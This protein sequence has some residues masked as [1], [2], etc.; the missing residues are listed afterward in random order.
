MSNPLG[1][2]GPP[3]PYVSEPADPRMITDNMSDAGSS[4]SSG[5][6]S[7]V[8]SR[9]TGSI[10]T[11]PSA[12]PRGSI[13]SRHTRAS[14]YS[15]A[16]TNYEEVPHALSL[17]EWNCGGRNVYLTGSWDNYNEKIPM[18]SI[19]PGNFRCTVKVPQERLEFKFI[20]DGVEKFNPDYPTMYTETGERVNVKH[21]DPDGKKNKTGA[22]RKIVSK[23]SGLD[24]YSPFHMAETLSMIVFRV[25]YVLTIP[26]AIYYFYWLAV[27]TERGGGNRKDAPVSWIVFMIAEMLSF[28]SAVIGLFGMWKPVKRKW[29]SLDSLKP[30]LPE[31]DWPSVDVIIAHYKEPP[32]QLRD[33]IRATL[34]L[35]YPSHLVRVIVADDGYFAT[36]KSVERSQLG[37]DMYQLLAE[38]AGYDPLLEEVMNDQGLVEHYT[39]LADDEILRPDCAKECHVFDF[40]PFGED[41]YA[42]GALP[43][44]TLVGRVK[45]A[46][47]HNK[48]GNI[49]NVLF[50]AGT[51]GKLALFLDADMR[52]TENMLL[53][54]VP[55]LLEEMRDDAVENTLML[56][57]DPEIGR[58]VNTAWRVNRDVAFIQAPQRFHNVD[59]DDVMAHRNALFYDGIIKGRDGFGMTP[60]V[61]TNCLWRREVLYEINGFVYGSVTEDTLTS[62]EVHRR[63]YISKYAAEDLAWGEAPVSVAAAMLQRQRW[64]K[65]AIMNGMKI[66]E[67]AADEKK[68]ALIARRRGEIDE[69]YEYRRHG[70]RPNNGL[71]RAMFW[72]D[73]TLYPLLGVAAFLYIFVAL[74]Y[75][76][77]AYPPIDPRNLRDLASAFITYYMIRYVAFFAAYSD[78]APIDILR[79]QETW[80][81]YNIC[82]VIGMWDALMGAKMSWVAN[83]GQRSRRVW[84]EWVNIVI[85]GLM[86]LGMIYRM[87]RFLYFEGGGGCDP[88]QSFG[89]CCFGIYIAGHMW[90]MA[91][92]SL[93]ERINPSA[94][95]DRIG[96][97]YEINTPVLYSA[98]TIIAVLVLSQ[99]A[100][101]KC[102]RLVQ[103][104]A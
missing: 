50:N 13:R 24:M 6:L 4:T 27:P 64:A 12:G 1:P 38:E 9:R 63:G 34:R 18:E 104:Q 30:P 87:V 83:T 33:T 25:F 74:Y 14:M 101:S 58:G 17:F 15:K 77:T 54:M 69:F 39:V 11:T 99:W 56:D 59:K 60:F 48:A 8:R 53:R 32:E 89:A 47:H 70:R 66:F 79:G 73:S 21:V 85:V 102:G 95:D 78:V 2:P 86:V 28:L 96:T 49:N 57:D 65:G 52:P 71:V 44:L 94:D 40:G 26:A 61:G 103:H 90:P 97:P 84:M 16:P 31:A 41:M 23:I 81:G 36:P 37:L 72:L 29:R 82:H 46:D 19:Q 43:R 88:W 42:P 20:V 35:D 100:I 98:V 5:M 91:A 62:N 67:T 22:V 10:D 75:L 80:F 92:V 45:P 7:D 55:L 76:I 51:D 93:N 68:R 3:M